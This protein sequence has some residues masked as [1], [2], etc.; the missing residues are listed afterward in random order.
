[1][2]LGVIYELSNNSYYRAIMPMRALEKRGHTVVW[3]ANIDD[4]VPVRELYSCDL[5]H[6]YR[7]LDRLDDLRKLSNRGVAISYDNDDNYAAAEVP[8][9]LRSLRGVRQ[10]RAIFRQLLDGA[11]L[12]D[13]TTTPSPVL[14]DVYRRAGIKNVTVIE[15][16]LE[17]AM[18]GFGSK[19]S[20]RSTIIGWI[21]AREHQLD[22]EKIPIIGALE[23]LLA[24][25]AD[26]R[27]VTVGLR[28]PLR[29]DRYEYVAEVAFP[30]L[31][32]VASRFDI[33]IAPLVDNAFNRSRSNAKLK[34]YAS[35]R[36]AWIASPTGPYLGLDG[37]GGR[38]ASD[39]RWFE[40]M[41]ELVR[42]S[43]M[44]RRL[45]RQALKWAKRE[46]ID[47]HV[48]AWEGAFTSVLRAR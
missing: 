23:R 1:M 33:G 2:R 21:A 48:G 20:E 45:A 44:R 8:D 32:T 17:R 10:N 43:G 31:L 12:A 46:T 4:D 14:A 11:R 28:L 22:R 13:L 3:P 6:C 47:Q 5:V 36:A 40:T 7:R 26:V 37:H 39:D 29:S 19:G 38:F 18:L 25:H 9:G 30:R 24:A 42:N 16:H 27:V 41:D 35:G 15:N 34:E